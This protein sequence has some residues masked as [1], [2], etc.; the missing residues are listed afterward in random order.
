MMF[1]PI[2]S[3]GETVVMFGIQRSRSSLMCHKPPPV[4]WSALRPSGLV[5]AC[6]KMSL[7]EVL[8]NGIGAYTHGHFEK[9]V[10]KTKANKPTRKP[11][12]RAAAWL[13]YA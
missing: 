5:F 12:P 1:G 6:K 11:R 8:S 2:L 10:Y 4:N 7:L 9:Q 3:F 13:I